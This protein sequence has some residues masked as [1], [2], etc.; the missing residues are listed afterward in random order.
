[1]CF[2]KIVIWKAE[3]L[4]ATQCFICW[5]TP[6]ST[7]IARASPGWSQDPWTPIWVIMWVVGPS[8]AFSGILRG[9]WVG[10]ELPRLNWHWHSHMGCQHCRYSLVHCSMPAPKGQC[11]IN[12][13]SKQV[14]KGPSDSLWK[15]ELAG[16]LIFGAKSFWNPCYMCMLVDSNRIGVVS[17]T[18][19]HSGL[20]FLELS[21]TGYRWPGYQ[22]CG[23][24]YTHCNIV[25]MVL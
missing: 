9:T 3:W 24:S 2:D 19:L 12:Q 1:M 21:F 10:S 20:L 25:N 22:F 7:T 16:E 11:W 15:T 5:L 14:R 23:L 8:T 4:K 13:H 17:T 18:F 6:Q